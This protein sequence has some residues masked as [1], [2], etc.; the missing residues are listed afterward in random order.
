MPLIDVVIGRRNVKNNWS[1]T[2]QAPADNLASTLEL[3][4]PAIDL[5][6]DPLPSNDEWYEL[7]LDDGVQA[8]EIVRCTSAGTGSVIVERAQQGTVSPSLWATGTKVAIRATAEL[9][10]PLQFT[11]WDPTRNLLAFGAGAG[12]GAG[13]AERAMYLGP[14]AG[15]AVGDLDD[16]LAIGYGATAHTANTAVIGSD[17]MPLHDIYIGRGQRATGSGAITLHASG[18]QGTDAEGMDLRLAGGAGTGTGACGKV[19]IAT[20]T[21]AGVS[22]EDDA[23]L[24]NRAEWNDAGLFWTYAGL[25]TGDPGNGAG[26]WKLGTVQAGA[27]ALDAANYVE[28]DIDGTFVKLLKAA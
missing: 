22:G 10:R 4:Q 3:P 13:G 15:A 27:V 25:K 12:D 17:D 6:I 16:V 9:L 14:A 24:T 1:T 7:T 21:P 8:P 2:L 5:L 18:G 19:I 20:A 26:T 11:R 28:V 23:L